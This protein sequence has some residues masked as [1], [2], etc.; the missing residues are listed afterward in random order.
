MVEWHSGKEKKRREESAI[1]ENKVLNQK[2]KMLFSKCVTAI[3]L[4]R[5]D[6]NTHTP[7]QPCR[8]VRDL[9]SMQPN[10]RFKHLTVCHICSSST[11]MTQQTQI[12]FLFPI[13]LPLHFT[14][15]SP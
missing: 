7:A 12:L 14:L 6:Y 8:R 10:Q 13:F 11:A 2:N 9:V 1:I 3:T 4:E 5:T 15:K